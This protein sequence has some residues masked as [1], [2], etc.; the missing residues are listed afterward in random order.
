M[1]QSVLDSAL[2]W[3]GTR[4][5]I[6]VFGLYLWLTFALGL[7]LRYRYYRAIVGL[8]VK[9]PSRWP[10]LLEL[11]KSHRTAFLTWPTLVPLGITLLLTVLHMMVYSL[12]YPD[13]Q[14][15]PRD[16]AGSWVALAATCSVG[17]VMLFYDLRGALWIGTFD[18]AEVAK[19]LDQAEYWLKTWV[20]S[21]L[22]ILTFGLINPRKMVQEEVRK[23]VLYF[24]ME[25]KKM[26]WAWSLQIVLRLCFGLS[27]WT[28]WALLTHN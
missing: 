7:L 22:R 26:M 16:L 24:N 14:V 17:A 18:Q 2:R 15:T 23:A 6:R 11:I 1:E 20:A 25:F 8:V 19:N 13:A 3:L 10:K 4:N 9:M 28:T 12:L 21:A 27:I 5:L